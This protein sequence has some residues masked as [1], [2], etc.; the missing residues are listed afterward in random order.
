MDAVCVVCIDGRESEGNS[1]LFCD[2]C[3][4][5][6]HQA[7]YHVPDVPEGD[8]FCDPCT[9]LLLVE[10]DPQTGLKKHRKVSV[11]SSELVRPCALCPNLEWQGGQIATIESE[12]VHM[13]CATY[14]PACEIST[15]KIVHV[16][17][18]Q[19]KLLQNVCELCGQDGFRGCMP[20]TG[21]CG[22]SFF[23]VTCAQLRGASRGYSAS[24]CPSCEATWKMKC[25]REQFEAELKTLSK[26]QPLEQEA[27]GTLSEEL[28]GGK[29][30]RS[31]FMSS[32]ELLAQVE[33][34]Q[35]PRL[36]CALKLLA[37]A[38]GTPTDS[39]LEALWAVWKKVKSRFPKLPKDIVR[40]FHSII[41]GE[42]KEAHLARSDQDTD[43]ADATETLQIHSAET[44]MHEKRH[45]KVMLG[46]RDSVMLT[47]DVR[48]FVGEILTKV[49]NVE[50][51]IGLAQGIVRFATQKT[52]GLTLAA[53]QDVKDLKYAAA[54]IGNADWITYNNLVVDAPVITYLSPS[55]RKKAFASKSGKGGAGTSGSS[56]SGK[57]DKSQ[58][59]SK[60]KETVEDRLG[61]EVIK[62]NDVNSNQ[63]TRLNKLA[64][65]LELNAR[66]EPYLQ[67]NWN[68]APYPKR[69][70]EPLDAYVAASGLKDVEQQELL[71]ILNTNKA[72]NCAQDEQCGKPVPF[73]LAKGTFDTELPCKSRRV[74]CP[75]SS[76]GKNNRLDLGK[77]V[78]EADMWGLDCYTRKNIQSVLQR[79]A[80]IHDE[81]IHRTFLQRLLLPVVYCQPPHR[82]YNVIHSLRSI[83]SACGRDT[84]PEGA[85][86]HA[87]G[88]T[89]DDYM[90]DDEAELRSSVQKIIQDANA[91]C[92]VFTV[93][94]VRLCCAGLLFAAR[95]WGLNCF[96]LHPKGVGV[97]C[98]K[99]EGLPSGTFVT[100][101]FGELYPPFRW[102]E[103]Q[104]AI[105]N[106]QRSVGFKPVLPDFYN[107]AVERH[108]DDQD[109]YDVAYIDP[110][111]RGNFASRLSHSCDP[112]CVTVVMIKD[113]KYVVTV[114]TLRDVAFG[115]ELTFDYSSVTEDENEFR[116][117]TCLC[118]SPRCRGSFLYYAG[119]GAFADVIN[120]S[121]NFL[122]RSALVYK[123]CRD[124][125]LYESDTK[126]LAKH[127]FKDA[128]LKDL[129]MW[130]RKWA[131]LVL[132]Y[133]EFEH[134]ELSH[135][136]C[137]QVNLLTSRLLY[138]YKSAVLEARGVMENRRQN[139]VITLNKLRYFL[140]AERDSKLDTSV[141]GQLHNAVEPLHVLSELEIVDHL[142]NNN[143]SIGSIAILKAL[144][145]AQDPK[146]V[147]A[148]TA[149]Q[150]RWKS[151][152]FTSVEPLRKVLIVLRDCLWQATSRGRTSFIAAGDLLTWYIYT[153]HFFSA[154]QYPGF[155]STPVVVRN[156]DIGR[157][158][159][160]AESIR[161]GGKASTVNECPKKSFS[162]R[163]KRI[164]LLNGEE[165]WIALPQDEE[166]SARAIEPSTRKPG[167][168]LL[169]YWYNYDLASGKV[170][171]SVC[172]KASFKRLT[173]E[174]TTNAQYLFRATL[175]NDSEGGF[176]LV[177]SDAAASSSSSSAK[178][179]AFAVLSHPMPGA[180]PYYLFRPRAT[181][182][183]EVDQFCERTR[184]SVIVS[185]VVPDEPTRPESNDACSWKVVGMFYAFDV[186]LPGTSK[187]AALDGNRRLLNVYAFPV[188]QF[189][190]NV[191]FEDLSQR[192]GTCKRV[193][194]SELGDIEQ[195]L[196]PLAPVYNQKDKAKAALSV[197][198]YQ[199]GFIW[200]QMAGWFKQ[201]VAAPDASLSA[202]RRGSLSMPDMDTAF[203][204]PYKDRLAIVER[205]ELNP[206]VMWPT[207][208]H[209]SFKNKAK[210]YGT[211]W[212][213]EALEPS[214]TNRARVLYEIKY[215]MKHGR[216]CPK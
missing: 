169:P 85:F 143:D 175:E 155:R 161:G 157:D 74:G 30:D 72:P 32:L 105:K 204:G 109:G 36:Q 22:V 205:L 183:P 167:P 27:V 120:E 82:A 100:E 11:K 29:F 159:S 131:S 52:E 107:I 79:I 65:E 214:S 184:G 115:E 9:Q 108:E 28:K 61:D 136:L 83:L 213:D 177:N 165:K 51:A 41:G 129:P 19:S 80:F 211:P 62:P 179:L 92:E 94:T 76:L 71:R 173:L 26:D 21:G 192:N 16:T 164:K 208:S 203:L 6:V 122:D 207:G 40:L 138:D 35:D 141:L 104:D 134:K 166:T 125:T 88:E 103:K 91:V 8:W 64:S 195:A 3:N 133:A 171:L 186:P 20:C 178:R 66:T 215:H 151:E 188:D 118:G 123:A 124:P 102:F 149:L 7:C 193:F 174:S 15:N 111:V 110:I 25:F 181:R 67:G 135:R 50:T 48:K 201:T 146:D 1:I 13:S 114:Y 63:W 117:A 106:V 57:D 139:I 198:K 200:G 162:V 14:N 170:S 75:K 2:G 176:A 24:R 99:E 90:Q 145:Y 45:R 55:Q 95:N 137:L 180:T 81:N 121:H 43:A 130:L 168:L 49:K 140:I 37:N 128:V 101:Y 142:W 78:K 47:F 152:K 212:F 42:Q 197:K 54:L 147:E 158:G 73:S 154:V 23:H 70:Y 189:E 156:V 199:S 119:L 206:S 96:R 194:Q 127:G 153:D 209:W 60:S 97:Q 113:G 12:W 163:C 39:E 86:Q 44:L 53:Q 33:H 58:S 187:I 126:R 87:F 59:K 18:D 68:K 196:N 132:E 10:R 148:F 56:G 172:T 31:P 46:F 160:V 190:Q 112:N 5:A 89:E 210:I 17:G 4:C 34:R 202:E 84:T 150:E 38:P 185:R 144:H 69:P 191:T 93:P 116:A 216:P 77:D 98:R 182:G